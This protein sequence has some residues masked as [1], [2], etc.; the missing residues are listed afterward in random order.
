MR[1]TLDVD[2]DVLEVAKGLAEA[3]HISVGKALS[4]LARRGVTAQTPLVEKNGFFVFAV[5]DQQRCFGP[6]DVQAAL[7]AEDRE[8]AKQFIRR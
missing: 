5:D 1:T 6:E 4:Y 3:R 7:D 8:F 2:S